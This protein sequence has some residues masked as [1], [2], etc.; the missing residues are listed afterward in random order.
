M[1]NEPFLPF[2]FYLVVL[3]HHHTQ[4]VVGIKIAV[5]FSYTSPYAQSASVVWT[6]SPVQVLRG[7]VGAS[8][9]TKCC[10]HIV[11]H[12]LFVHQVLCDL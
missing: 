6:F 7:C 10:E 3:V 12:F 11:C 9:Y 1:I 5:N 8:S 2:M 4:S